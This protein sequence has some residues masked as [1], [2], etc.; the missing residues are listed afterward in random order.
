MVHPG[1]YRTIPP[2]CIPG[3]TTLVYTHL[4][5]PGY[6]SVLH[7]ALTWTTVLIWVPDDDVLGSRRRL[8]TVRGLP[9]PLFLSFLLRMEEASAQSYSLFLVRLTTKIG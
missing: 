5:H 9:A 7:I 2:W 8:I 4:Y 6:T 3:Y 1:I